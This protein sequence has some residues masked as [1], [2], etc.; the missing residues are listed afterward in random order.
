MA[1]GRG[2]WPQ[3]VPRKLSVDT[4]LTTVSACF[5]LLLPPGLAFHS[6]VHRPSS[7]RDSSKRYWSLAFSSFL[8]P[9]LMNRFLKMGSLVLSL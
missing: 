2:W 6:C 8:F 4:P 7:S 5:F 1:L 3:A 9:V